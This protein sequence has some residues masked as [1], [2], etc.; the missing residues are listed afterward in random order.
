MERRIQHERQAQSMLN[1]TKGNGEVASARKENAKLAVVLRRLESQR[2]NVAAQ[3]ESS[4]KRRELIVAKGDAIQANIEAD[5]EERR[6]AEMMA[7]AKRAQSDVIRRLKD[8]AKSTS[9]LK[10]RVLD[11]ETAHGDI[12]ETYTQLSARMADLVERRERF[13]VGTITHLREKYEHALLSTSSQQ[14]IAQALKRV[15]ERRESTGTDGD[16]A[17]KYTRSIERLEEVRGNLLTAIREE[18]HN[19]PHLSH[20]LKRARSLLTA[21]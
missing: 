17:Q 9:E 4:V 16:D 8:V 11:L 7:T 6:E 14:K 5:G 13:R 20:G 21:V 19:H 1:P 3:V 10:S 2:N 15:S 18:I 12:D